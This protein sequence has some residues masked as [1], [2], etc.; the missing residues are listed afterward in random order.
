MT[1]DNLYKLRRLSAKGQVNTSPAA[2]N[3]PG[4]RNF[5]ENM[6][7]GNF[8][9]ALDDRILISKATSG[10]QADSFA[11]NPRVDASLS[12]ALAPCTIGSNA[13]ASSLPSSTPH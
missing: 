8:V 5:A 10:F 6:G 13:L 12:I 1:R 4:S 7:I 3:D 11:S 2:E 9:V